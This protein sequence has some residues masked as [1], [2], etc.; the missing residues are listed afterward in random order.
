MGVPVRANLWQPL[1]H[2]VIRNRKGEFMQLS[3]RLGMLGGKL[4]I[5]L[6]NDDVLVINHKKY[7]NV[8]ES[9]HLLDHI[10]PR[11]EL[12]KQF[13]LPAAI[14]SGMFFIAAILLWWYGKIH[15]QPPE[16]VGYLF[17]SIVCFVAFIISGV[18]A[19]KSRVNVICFNAPDGRRLFSIFGN[20]PSIEEVKKFSDDLVKRIERIRYNAEISNERMA[21]ILEKHVEFL[22]EQGVL[23][24]SEK[25]VA[26]DRIQ[27]KTKFNVVKLNKNKNV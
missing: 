25:K 27:N 19:I 8:N 26:I 4:D 14:A 5:S 15:S 20:K 3:Q 22:C 24:L 7:L 21:D 9:K 12:Y 1:I 18:K 6:G 11:Y 23:S 16:D 13:S 2:D 17:I 10:D